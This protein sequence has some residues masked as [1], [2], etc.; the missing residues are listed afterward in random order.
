[1]R[2][3]DDVDGVSGSLNT[4]SGDQTRHGQHD[5]LYTSR[6]HVY[7]GS[8][9]DEDFIPHQWSKFVFSIKLPILIGVISIISQTSGE[10]SIKQI[11][12]RL[13]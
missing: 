6:Q 5:F 10:T 7:L 3:L 9:V 1:M 11:Y 2:H 8:F 12:E 4:L 13:V